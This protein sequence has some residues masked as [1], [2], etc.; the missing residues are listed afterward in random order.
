MFQKIAKHRANDASN[1]VHRPPLGGGCWKPVPNGM[2]EFYCE[3]KPLLRHLIVNISTTIS[4]TMAESVWT[5]LL[6]RQGLSLVEAAYL[7][8][9]L[10]CVSISVR[11]CRH[12]TRFAINVIGYL[13]K[14]KSVTMCQI[15]HGKMGWRKCGDRAITEKIKAPSWADRQPARH[16]TL[17]QHDLQYNITRDLTKY[18]LLITFMSK[19]QYSGIFVIDY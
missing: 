5:A 14:E 7:V 16:C 9:K 6:F 11:D 19:Y 2:W 13:K 3:H 15:N 17:L 4:I 18:F 10:R 12:K 8:V 1:D